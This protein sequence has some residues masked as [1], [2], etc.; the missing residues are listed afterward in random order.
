MHPNNK[1]WLFLVWPILT[2]CIFL[3]VTGC[4][5]AAQHPQTG[6]TTEGVNKPWQIK[7]TPAENHPSPKDAGQIPN[8][9]DPTLRAPEQAERH[10]NPNPKAEADHMAQVLTGIPGVQHAYVL[11]TGRVAL[12][13]VDLK[14]NISG[15][16]IDTVKYSVKEAAE[17]TGPGY[18]AIVS[19]DVDTVARIRQ[20]TAGIRH[21]RPI[22]SF[23]DEIADILS[24]LIPET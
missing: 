11:L 10:P 15:S 17:R 4:R 22:S 20:M 18:R 16:K 23:T 2:L 7:S 21:G 8:S 19:A 3:T 6:P 14:S 13:G 9:Q 12:V 1:I 24:R 5:Q